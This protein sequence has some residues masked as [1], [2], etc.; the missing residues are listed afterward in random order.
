MRYS[1]TKHIKSV[2][3]FPLQ[4]RINTGTAEK[5]SLDAPLD[6]KAMGFLGVFLTTG[7]VTSYAISRTP[8]AETSDFI[9]GLEPLF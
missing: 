5:S 8:A 3:N 9:D 4:E 7:L 6:E 1:A 2:D